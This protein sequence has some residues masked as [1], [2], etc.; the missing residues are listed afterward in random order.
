MP[1]PL[2]PLWERRPH[3][4]EVVDVVADASGAAEVPG[5]RVEGHPVLAGLGDGNLS[6]AGQGSGGMRVCVCEGGENSEDLAGTSSPT[7]GQPD[8]AAD[9]RC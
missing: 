5:V 1:A 4:G 6:G 3:R 9:G 7:K 2:P 8:S